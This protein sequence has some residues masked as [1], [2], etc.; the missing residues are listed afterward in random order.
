[1][2][3]SMILA[4]VEAVQTGGDCELSIAL[5]A[6][7]SLEFCH[8]LL[9]AQ[10]DSSLLGVPH[11]AGFASGSSLDDGPEGPDSGYNLDLDWDFLLPD[12]GFP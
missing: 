12:S 9:L 11:N 3:L 6:K 5:R 2:F 8:D 10:A 1:M 4:K 7:D